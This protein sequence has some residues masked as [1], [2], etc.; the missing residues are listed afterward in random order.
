MQ[1]PFCDKIELISEISGRRS[2]LSYN[3]DQAK[4]PLLDAL[5]DY[6]RN[7]VSFHMP[8]HRGGAAAPKALAD[9]VG[10]G[11]FC[12]DQTEVP[13]LDDLHNPG[14]VI[15][16]AQKLAAD[17]FGADRTFFLVNGTS[18]GIHAL[19]AGTCSPGAKVILPRNI[20]RS[21]L[22]GL[23]VS[24]ADPVYIPVACVDGFGIAA[25]VNP[26]DLESVWRE[27]P[28]AS[29]AMVVNPTY[30]GL[31]GEVDRMAA[32]S[33]GL[34]KPLYVDE[35]HGGHLRFH[36]G[37]PDDAMSAGADGAVQSTHKL[38]GSLTQSSMLHLQGNL[39]DCE[40]I[41]SVLGMVQTTSPSY[42]LMSSLDAARHQ[43]VHKG[44]GLLEEAINLSRWLRVQLGQVRGIDVFDLEDLASKGFS[45]CRLDCTKIL[46]SAARLGLSGYDLSAILRSDY[47]IQVEMADFLNVLCMVTIGTTKKDCEGLVFA[48]NDI[49]GRTPGNNTRANK[50]GLK[51][52]IAGSSPLPT[53]KVMT[54]REAWICGH[55]ALPLREA[56]GKVSAES[57]AVYPP[58]IPTL[59][60]GE[61]ITPEIVEY[62]SMLKE[63]QIP[64]QGPRDP[65]L[66][67]LEVVNG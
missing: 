20:H 30:H 8:A 32:V 56:V 44:H 64:L 4:T 39:I 48:V 54:P 24:G 31:C 12:I 17:A 28:E 34:G 52:K 16:E 2:C 55:C 62:L 11:M 15:D 23:I 63:M 51:W 65:G 35:A 59:L 5:V 67:K 18:C 41:A 66:S 46:I 40:S 36:P 27:Y 14:G 13:G 49:S 26:D 43:M 42:V 33:H 57:V 53:V 25:P 50:P 37:L 9:F 38:G 58:G 7:N 29:A 60:P 3:V 47:N 10:S 45:G 22:W 1:R 21:V 19:L 61:V 6:C